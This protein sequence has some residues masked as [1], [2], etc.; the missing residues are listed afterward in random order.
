MLLKK[1]MIL[2]FS[3]QNKILVGAGHSEQNGLNYSAAAI[4]PKL[5]FFT[6]RVAGE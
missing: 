4:T 2:L 5:L 3:I 1:K 6:S